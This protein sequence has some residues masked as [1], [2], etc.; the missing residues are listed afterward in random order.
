MI[1]VMTG[2]P[3]SGKSTAAKRLLDEHLKTPYT[4]AAIVSADDFFTADDGTYE[5][6]L[7]ARGV[8]HQICFRR[9]EE[10]CARF[11]QQ[12][13]IVVDNTNLT[14]LERANYIETAA[15]HGHTGKVVH[16]RCPLEICI[17]RR[18]SNN[19]LNI[20]PVP[21]EVIQDMAARFQDPLVGWE[22]QVVDNA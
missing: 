10:Y 20:H 18:D 4:Q 19:P 6:I 12:D 13:L 11:R 16:V 1:I 9:F 17:A 8:A 7:E 15:G 2:L 14:N 3:G 21:P 22:L 5:Y